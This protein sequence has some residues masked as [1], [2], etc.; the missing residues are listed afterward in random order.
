MGSTA[1]DTSTL[2]GCSCLV[3]REAKIFLRSLTSETAQLTRLNMDDCGVDEGECSLGSGAFSV[4][5]QLRCGKVL[6]DSG[7][8]K[9]AVVRRCTVKGGRTLGDVGGSL[10]RHPFLSL[11]GFVLH[12]SPP[13]PHRPQPSPQQLPASSHQGEDLLSLTP[14]CHFSGE[15]LTHC[16]SAVGGARWRCRSSCLCA[17]T[18][19][20]TP[21]WGMPMSR[22]WRKPLLASLEWTSAAPPSRTP[23]C[24]PWDNT[25]GHNHTHH[26]H[27]VTR[28]LAGCDANCVVRLQGPTCSP[29]GLH[30]CERRGSASLGIRLSETRGAE[31]EADAPE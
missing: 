20:I 9:A 28:S 12:L 13:C 25:A 3:Q 26:T 21:G 29:R 22:L 16:S 8:A 31:L 14:P 4:C 5:S 30:H 7:M 27:D 18:C 19:P 11:R 15:G 17:W 10:D 24:S 1:C 6:L 23:H 2:L